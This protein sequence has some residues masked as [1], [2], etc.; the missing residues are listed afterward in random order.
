MHWS[1]LIAALLSSQMLHAQVK[2]DHRN[3]KNNGEILESGTKQTQKRADAFTRIRS[4]FW[5]TSIICSQE[6]HCSDKD[7]KT[8]G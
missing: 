7:N 1:V 6:G 5:T 3:T 8:D 4:T 2:K